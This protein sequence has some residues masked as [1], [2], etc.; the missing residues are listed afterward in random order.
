MGLL[1]RVEKRMLGILK[2]SLRLILVLLVTMIGMAYQSASADTEIQSFDSKDAMSIRSQELI[3]ATPSVVWSV[4]TNYN[5]LKNILP[6]YRR[7]QLV[8]N[9]PKLLDLSLS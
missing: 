6:G 8:Q 3:S 5:H 1:N 2:I 9:A 4:M 7:S